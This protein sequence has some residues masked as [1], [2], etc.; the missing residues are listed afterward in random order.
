MNN[1]SKHRG[2]NTV[3][4]V[5]L[6]TASVGLSKDDN[7]INLAKPSTIEF[8]LFEGNNIRN[9]LG[10]H[11]H[12]A[13]HY[14]T[15]DAGLEWPTGSGKTAIFAS[16]IWV[17]GQVDGEIRS[18]ASE[19]TSEWTPGTIPYD[20]QTKLPTNNMPFNAPEHQIYY[21][22]KGN[23]SDPLSDSY[24]REYATW[25]ASHGAPAHDGEYFTD[26]NGNGLR[27]TNEGYED[28]NGNGSYDAPDG[29]LVTGED[30]PLLGGARQAWWV[31][32]DWDT[33]AHNNLWDTQPLGLEAQAFVFVRDDDPIFN[34]VQFHTVLL[35]NK[36]GMEIDSCYYGY[37]A[38]VDV[39]DAN[40]DQGG[41]DSSLSLN[42]VYNG[43]PVDQDYGITPPA[44]G[45]S[46]L[47]GPIIDSPGD[48]VWYD[49]IS[50][51]GQ[52]SLEMTAS[53]SI[54]K[55][56]FFG[57]AWDAQSAFSQLKGLGRN[58]QPIIDPWGNRTRFH[59]SGDPV[60]NSGWTSA[61]SYSPSDRRTL[62]SSG[63][64]RLEPWDDLN[65]NGLADF[66]EPGVQIIH[67]ALIIVDGVDHLDAITHLK[68]VSRYTHSAY[69]NGFEIVAMEKP[70]LSVSSQDQE[71]ILNWYG[72]AD[73]YE[74]TALGDYE[75]EG[76]NLYQGASS[77][78]PW[79]RLATYDRINNIGTIYDQQYDNTGY[80]ETRTVQWGQDSGLD[81]IISIKED[82]LNDDEP[83]VNNKQYYFS[84]SAYAYG[85][86]ALPKTLE[87]EKQIVS[88]RP[89]GSFSGSVPRDSLT[90]TQTGDSEI[91]TSVNVLDPSQLTGLEYELGFEYDSSSSM[92]RWHVLRDDG[93]STDTLHRSEWF[94]NLLREWRWR[95]GYRHILPSYYFDGFEIS[96]SDISFN[97]PKIN[98]NWYQT[99]NIEEGQIETLELLAVS[100]G[101]VDSLAWTDATMSEIV[102]LDTLAGPDFVWD[103]FE[104][105][106]I[107]DVGSFILDREVPHDI[108]IQAFTSNFGGIGGDRLADM[109]G[110][111]GGSTDLEFLQSDL[112]L[113][114]TE[115][116]QTATMWERDTLANSG[117]STKMDQIPFEVWDIE[118]NIQQ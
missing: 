43:S 81:H 27:E 32:N 46:I 9:F 76:Y 96:V 107:S 16:G 5:L 104:F 42:F 34:N 116:G 2:F 64:F 57:D 84:L 30:P 89:H 7:S 87:S 114:F 118:R 60:T 72:G 8:E 33:T 11:G 70:Q 13:S 71:L 111:G 25:P 53:T 23:S 77:N 117:F 68:Y 105:S 115:Y 91:F 69:D 112:E 73:E 41:C 50:Y 3:F 78:G 54:I 18:A 80:L 26:L 99:V 21:I 59:V 6:F 31:M 39:G 20:T 67:T 35:V 19:F 75:F 66:G 62:M 108:I 85:E 40:D 82:V 93:F 38:D 63:P 15:G 90:I 92:G 55:S 44:V 106:E 1:N 94:E 36:G 17:L 74:A 113:R 51:P 12:L 56:S 95:Y 103:N 109:P 47:Q 45:Y 24:N 49:G 102:H 101:G 58:G 88:I 14:P 83:L 37:W 79:T 52:R 29:L 100:P 28:F 61:N 98:R 86:D 110:I 10:N 65:N 97:P 4:L 22:Q 48:T